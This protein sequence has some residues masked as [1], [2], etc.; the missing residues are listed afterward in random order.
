[1]VQVAG[2]PKHISAVS[3]SQ[4]TN[5]AEEESLELHV[6]RCRVPCLHVSAQAC[7]AQSAGL[8]RDAS[9]LLEHRGLV[10]HEFS[11]GL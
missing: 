8:L 10:E 5:V 11:E 3:G 7:S 9:H 4:A 1:M 6:M 2:R